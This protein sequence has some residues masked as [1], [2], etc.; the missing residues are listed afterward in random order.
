M[1]V[2]Y[3]FVDQGDI[4]SRSSKPWQIYKTL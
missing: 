2:K 1:S 3:M 4:C